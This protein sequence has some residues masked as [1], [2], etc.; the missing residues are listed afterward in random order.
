MPIAKSLLNLLLIAVAGY[1]LLVTLMYFAQRS[2]MYPGATVAGPAPE[3]APWGEAHLL[4]MADG[5]RLYALHSPASE[6]R[7]TLLFFHGNGDRITQYGFL[8]EGLASHGIGLLALSYRGFTGSSGRPSE[9]DLLADALTAHDW[10]AARTAGP[11]VLLGQS[12][13]TGVAVHLARERPQVAGL[14][15]ISA[16]DSI[17]NVA[18]SAYFFLP[19][20][21]LIRDRFRSDLWIADVAQPKLFVHGVRD[22]VIP[23]R[24]G[25]ALYEAAPE[26]KEMRVYDAYGHNDIWSEGLLSDVVRFTEAVAQR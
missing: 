2:L 3:Q 14:I 1:G 10:L 9:Q 6:G 18:A 7:P 17:E 15:L 19:V 4:D 23:I 21:W 24:H 11:V 22:A 26:P 12:L 5:E 16:Y 20:R 8:A 13:G 25:Q